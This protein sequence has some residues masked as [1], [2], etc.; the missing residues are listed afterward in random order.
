MAEL[1]QLVMACFQLLASIWMVIV[2]VAELA[3]RHW[4][5]LAW[6]IFWL[7]LVPWPMFRSR[8][9]QGGWVSFLLLFFLV[10]VTWGLVATPHWR[11]FGIAIPGV[12][13]KFGIGLL[14]TVVAFL[15]GSLQDQW[16]WTPIPIEFAGPPEP[17]PRAS[18]GHEAHHPDEP[19][20]HPGHGHH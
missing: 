14:W 9:R 1:S 8:L 13:E 3:A 11:L 7:F 4:V 20:H 15:C 5:A 19:P 10:C 16:K 12:V 18:G 2:S 17:A 6:I